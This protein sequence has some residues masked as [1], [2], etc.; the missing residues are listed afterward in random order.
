VVV[1][2]KVVLAILLFAAG[3]VALVAA[4]ELLGRG[5]GRKGARP[6]A[7]RAVHRVAGYAFAVLLA[8]LVVVGVGRLSVTGDQMPLRAVFHMVLAV[9]I[10]AVL[11]VK[12][13][14]ARF[15]RPLLKLTPALRLF[16]FVMTL[17]VVAISA[18]FVAVTGG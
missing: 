3:C 10:V 16:L 18:G 6:E 9:G 7:P 15:Y 1:D 2:P 8:A 5:D 17:V 11:V 4:L 14:V 13:L 12:V